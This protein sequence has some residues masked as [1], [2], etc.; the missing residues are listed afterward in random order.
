[1]LKFD[2]SLVVAAVVSFC[3]GPA[4]GQGTFTYTFSGDNSPL[5]VWATFQAGDQAVGTG[6]LTLNNISSGYVLQ[7]GQQWR[8]DYLK[9]P[10]NSITGQ[11]PGR[12]TYTELIAVLGYY[13]LD[14]IAP[15]NSNIYLW[16]MGAPIADY[17]GTSGAWTMAY[18][19]PEPH[20]IP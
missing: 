15:V 12:E 10:V 3:A 13:E 20:S 18:S 1:M 19:V 2:P 14:I 16:Q 9:F 11:V 17:S 5:N 7:G 6:L 4:S 8:I